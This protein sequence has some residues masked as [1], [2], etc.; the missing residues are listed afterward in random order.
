YGGR[1]LAGPSGMVIGLVIA[2]V[3]NIGSYWFGDRIA[4]AMSGAKPLA[5]ADAPDVYRVVR[6]VAGLA[7]VPMPHVYLVPQS[8]PN[9]FATGRDPQHAAV[10]VTAGILD[11][12]NDRELTAVLAH[13]IGHVT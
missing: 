3:M 4:L 1:L 2:V 9:A 8:A 6:R 11:I 7:N 5:E 13:E 12:V 10:A